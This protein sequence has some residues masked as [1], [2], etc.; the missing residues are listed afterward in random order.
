[1]ACETFEVVP[2][3]DAETPQM[4]TARI[5]GLYG[6]AITAGMPEVP[7][8][9]SEDEKLNKIKTWMDQTF[10]PDSRI[11]LNLSELLKPT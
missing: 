4:K 9:S 1:M 6:A 7:A 5:E 11:Y 10:I 3:P 2:A 8:T